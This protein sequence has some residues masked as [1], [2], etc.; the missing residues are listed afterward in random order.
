MA[1]GKRGRPT[2]EE[3]AERDRIE[4]ERV[5][6]LQDVLTPEQRAAALDGGAD[7]SARVLVAISESARK[8]RSAAV[9]PERHM[10][11]GRERVVP[12][13]GRDEDPVRQAEADKIRFETELKEK[14]AAERDALFVDLERARELWPG[15]DTTIT[16]QDIGW[17]A[18]SL[19]VRGLRPQ[20]A[21]SRLAW[22]LLNWAKDDPDKFYTALVARLLPRD[23][24]AA[25]K[26]EA[27]AARSY[28]DLLERLAGYVNG[29]ESEGSSQPV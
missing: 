3:V 12:L 20:D 13:F 2:R 7:A 17:V 10:A 11:G 1:S 23:E 8:T 15:C 6:A 16:R 21:P 9:A 4:A 18:G 19:F 22:G 24:D 14:E 26:A 28:G 25:A 27:E 5:R 29:A